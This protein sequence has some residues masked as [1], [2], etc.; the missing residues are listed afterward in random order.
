M[1]EKR[2]DLWKNQCAV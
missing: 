1:E 2:L